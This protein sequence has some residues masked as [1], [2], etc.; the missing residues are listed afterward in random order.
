MGRAIWGTSGGFQGKNGANVGRWLN[1][2][3]IVGPLP[4]PS[5]TPPSTAQLN[6]RA[7]FGLV[8]SWLRVVK[9][10]IRIGFNVHKEKASPWNAAVQYNLEYAV[11]GVAPNF[12]MNY[13]MVLFCKGE[14]S[15]P[16][17]VTVATAA[18][19]N[20]EFEWDTLFNVG[21]GADTDKATF[22][23]YNPDKDLFVVLAGAVTRVTGT[24]TMQLP[25][26]FTGDLVQ[27]YMSLL[28]TDGKVSS[29]S[30][31]AGALTVV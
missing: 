9:G 20:L 25:V 24:F 4:H 8:T 6:Q 26:S 17:D 31:F 10:V 16:L 27:C 13:P 2:Q 28:S 18:G 30:V 22:V 23:V 14:L 12:T 3:N 19:A 15:P 29:D 7:R 1:G 21:F 11:T 5:Q